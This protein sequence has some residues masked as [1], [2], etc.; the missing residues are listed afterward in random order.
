VKNVLIYGDTERSLTLR[1]EVPLAIV[2][3]FLYLETGER[4]AV[5]TN[6]LEESRIAGA[7]PELEVLLVGDYG[8]DE[9][10]AQGNPRWWVGQELCVR[11]VESLGIGDA[12]V[13]PDF[14]LALADRLR[15]A[16]VTIAADESLFVERRRRKS[17]AEMAGIRR[18]ADVAVAAMREAAR[19]LA[20]A[21]IADGWLLEDGEPLTAESV[22]ERIRELCARGGAPAPPDIIV[23]AN[24]PGGY[25]GH[26]PGSG[27]LPAHVPIQVDLWPHDERSGCWADMT[28]TFVRGEPSDAVAAAQALVLD[29]HE[30]ACAAVAAGA[31]GED[32]YGVACELFEAAG[33]PTQRTKQPGETLRAGFFF[34]LGHGVGLDVHEEPF[35]CIGSKGALIAG[36]VI[37]VEP[38]LVLPGVGGAGVEDLLLVTEDGAERLTGAC[39]YELVL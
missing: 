3:A 17:A 21:T 24:D 38:G 29:A 31:V 14:P 36:D 5:L 39:G 12:A 32:L 27:P 26:D 28:R 15:L 13:P 2:D 35:L 22:R 10:I 30:R 18:A 25:S 1:H 20:A 4:R 23:R 37:A 8:L 34:C 19:I 11:V 9:L 33:H 6:A 16:G 7:A